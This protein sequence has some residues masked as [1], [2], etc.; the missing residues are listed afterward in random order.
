MAREPMREREIEEDRAPHNSSTVMVGGD[1]LNADTSKPLNFNIVEEKSKPRVVADVERTD[2]EQRIYDDSEDEDTRLAYDVED[3]GIEERRSRRSRRNRAAREARQSVAD[4]DQHIMALNQRIDQLN[5][6]VMGLTQGHAGLTMN[7]LDTQL[8]AARQA[9]TLADDEL[10]RAV[11]AQDGEKFREVQRLRDEAAARVFQLDG[12]KNSILQEQRRRAEG[13]SRPQPQPQ[14]PQVPSHLAAK[15]RE[16]TD[17]F[18]SRFTYFDPN[19]TD[20][21]TRLMK[22]IDDGVMEDGY[23]PHTKEYW[24][25]LERRLANRGFL[26]DRGAVEDSEDDD[27]SNRSRG[28]GANRNSHGGLPPSSGSNGGARRRT[29]TETYTI[30]AMGRQYLEDEGLLADNLTEAQLAKR[31]RVIR[32]WRAMEQRAKRGEFART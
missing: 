3:E 16:F 19:G 32:G 31:N 13:G 8:N 15:A 27:R 4:R 1:G 12:A 10:A 7:T 17:I 21:D 6:M 18:M 30:P 24:H 20:E 22:A 26:P 25:Q 2:Q 9:L 28:N 23:L 5:N 14:A 11:S 29:G